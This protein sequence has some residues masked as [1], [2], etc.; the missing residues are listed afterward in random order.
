[1][2]NKILIFSLAY[3]PTLVGGAE[4][5]VKEITDRIKESEASF[6]MVTLRHNRKLPKFE[7]IGNVSVYR[8]TTPKIFFPIVAFLRA[9]FLNHKKQ[10]DVIWS[11]M[12]NRAGFAALFFK[13]FHPKTRYI[14]TLQEGDSLGYPKERMGVLW[15][16]LKRLFGQIFTR[17]DA[18][19]AI[20]SYLANWS[21]QMGNNK[22]FLVPNGVDVKR[23]TDDESGIKVGGVEIRKRLGIGEN[24]K[25]VITT[26][27]L[28]RKNGV[29]ILIKAMTYLPPS[30]KLLI[31]GVGELE[32]EL[33][34]LAHGFGL[35]D[36]VIFAGFVEPP[37]IPTYLGA[38]DVFARPSRTE[39]QG[40]SFL[41]AMAVGTPVVATAVGGIP[42]F[43]EDKKTGLF[44]ESENA[45][46]LARKINIFLRDGEVRKIVIDNARIMIS[47]RYDWNKISVEM[48]KVLKA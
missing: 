39:G 11:I 34:I 30:V 21:R 31:V 23:I 24:E 13:I 3:Y 16:F 9:S 25:V 43:L 5:A 12:A 22:V 26:S 41:E 42:D 15:P 29:D 14:L 4:V 36:R 19:T 32:N 27:R 7:K 18:V 8:I 33:K 2:K 28:V 37:E 45:E 17:A 10:Y 40:I 20:S 48:E 46:D 1:M 35:K 47:E 44:C 6:D 38:A